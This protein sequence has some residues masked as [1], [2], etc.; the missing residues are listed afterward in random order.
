MK[1][2]L[3]RLVV[4]LS[5]LLP[6]GVAWA[7]GTAQL[8]G[9]VTDESGAV[10]P[11]VGVTA[12]QTDTGTVRTATSDATGSWSIQSLPLGPYKVEIVLQGF[13]TFVQT[14]VVLQVNASPVI[15]TALP[16]GNV[17]ESVTVAGA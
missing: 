10:L 9:K 4:V 16:L 2:T 7:Q 12:T 5:L 13:R 3:T 17:E 15:N 11:A 8:N 14:G 6:R 1:S